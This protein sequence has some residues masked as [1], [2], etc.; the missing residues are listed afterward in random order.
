MIVCDF[1]DEVAHEGDAHPKATHVPDE[2]ADA[3]DYSN[4]FHGGIFQHKVELFDYVEGLVFDFGSVRE[5]FNIVVA[6]KIVFFRFV[7]E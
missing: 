2:L 3:V 4:L 7:R 6:Q 1:D 5:L